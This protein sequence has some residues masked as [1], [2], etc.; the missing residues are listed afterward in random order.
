MATPDRV[1][2]LAHRLAAG[3]A[4]T[5]LS[6]PARAGDKVRVARRRLSCWARS[7]RTAG[8][9]PGAEPPRACSIRPDRG[10]LPA[11][12]DY[13][14]QALTNPTI[15][16]E[17][18]HRDPDYELSGLVQSAF[19]IANL[20]SPGMP[21]TGRFPA[22]PWPDPP[23]LFSL[24]RLGSIFFGRPQRC[25][26]CGLYLGKAAIWHSQERSV[27]T[28]GWPVVSLPPTVAIRWPATYRAKLRE[29]DRVVRLAHD[30]TTFLSRRQW[31]SRLP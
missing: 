19:A 31:S 1:S 6:P 4:W 18:A 11:A 12:A 24:V 5:C 2:G 10:A 27:A 7:R 15:P 20:D 13:A 25:T 26:I 8:R 3:A 16:L 9:S 22:R 28:T 29:P 23:Q 17:V 30:G 14:S 21:S